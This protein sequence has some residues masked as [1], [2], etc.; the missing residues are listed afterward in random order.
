MLKASGFLRS[1]GAL[2]CACTFHFSVLALDVPATL[3]PIKLKDIPSFKPLT[4]SELPD[5]MLEVETRPTKKGKVHVNGLLTTIN[6]TEFEKCEPACK[7]MLIKLEPADTGFL[8]TIE[9]R[10]FLQNGKA[11]LAVTLLGFNEPANDKAAR[12]W[13]S[14]LYDAG[15]H[16]LSFDSLIRNNMNEATGHGVAGNFI[17]ESRLVAK[18]IEATLDKRIRGDAPI[19]PKVSSVRLLGTSYGG[20]LAAQCLRE[21]EALLWPLDRVLILSTPLNM[22]VAAKRLDTFAREDKPFFGVLALAKLLNGYT[23]REAMPSAKE[24][25]LMRAG[26]GYVFHGDLQALAKSNISRYAPEIPEKLKALEE[27]PEQREL[28]EDVLAAQK[29]RH[30]EEQKELESRR[31]SMG[32]DEYEKAK[33]E[34][35]DT[36]KVQQ[37]VAKRKAS[38]VME[39]NFND[40]VF[41]LLKPYWKLKR[42]ESTA[43]T[44]PDV[45]KGA[46]NF[47]Q[48]FIAADDPL[49]EAPEVQKLQNELKGNQLTII[50]H[51]GHLGFTG[52]KWCAELVKKFFAAK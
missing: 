39:W 31:D 45:I 29:T 43:V 9:V 11:P 50:P 12:A 28:Y 21:P 14:Y 13:Q 27:Q 37:L 7:E 4:M 36:H 26:I 48:A 15:C 22:Q 2:A 52:T 44:L 8:K 25:A 42:G 38:D 30:A 19:R 32:K 24:E 18:I 6:Y 46:P 16:V 3:D 23:P 40:Y 41:L 10:L 35:H 33:R 20:L 1:L 47:V 5:L 49:N 17:E 34:L 51:G